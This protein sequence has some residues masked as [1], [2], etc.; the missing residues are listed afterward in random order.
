[1]RRRN[2]HTYRHQRLVVAVVFVAGIV[3]NFSTVAAVV[4]ENG[5]AWLG[6]LDQ[7]PVRCEDVVPCRHR[8]FSVVHENRDVLVLE[9]VDGLDVLDL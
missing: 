9:A 6:A 7:L 2:I 5:V 4:K 8:V 3:P 1:M